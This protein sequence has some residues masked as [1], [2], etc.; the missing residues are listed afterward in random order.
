VGGEWVASGVLCEWGLMQ[1]GF[2][3]SRSGSLSGKIYS[4]MVSS[5]ILQKSWGDEPQVVLRRS[6]W[7]AHI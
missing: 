7:L 6:F 1:V 2:Y 5:K 3:A 4:F